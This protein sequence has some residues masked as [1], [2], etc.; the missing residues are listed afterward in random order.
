MSVVATMTHERARRPWPPGSPL[1]EI[2]GAWP[3]R[4]LLN[5][6]P[7]TGDVPT[8]AFIASVVSDRGFNFIA[9]LKFRIHALQPRGTTWFPSAVASSMEWDGVPACRT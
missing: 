1:P 4:D 7:S 6:Q 3:C 5:Q 8:I 9:Q 2:V